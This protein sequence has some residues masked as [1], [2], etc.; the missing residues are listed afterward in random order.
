[1]SSQLA[2]MPARRNAVK[3]RWKSRSRKKNFFNL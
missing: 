2:K 1:M 3:R